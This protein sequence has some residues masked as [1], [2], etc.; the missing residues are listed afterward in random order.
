MISATTIPLLLLVATVLAAFLIVPAMADTKY[1]TGS[2]QIS[3]AI[4]GTNEFSPGD[5][6]TLM[7]VVENRGLNEW[8]FARSDI[9]DPGDL[10]N[11]AKL[12]TVAMRPG[13]APVTVKSDPQKIGDLK[14]G[15]KIVV[16]FNTKIFY[17]AAAGTYNLPLDF[18]YTYLWAADQYGLD[19]IQYYYRVKNDT[20]RLPIKIKAEVRPG[21]ISAVPRHLNV[22]SEGYLDLRVKNIGSLAGKKAVIRT[23]QSG[24]SPVIPT[25]NSVY[26]G[27]FPVNATMDCTFKISASRD[28]QGQTYPLDVYV[29][30]E[31]QNGDTVD[32]DRAT[33]GVPVGKKIGFA[34]ASPPEEIPPGTKKVITVEY[35]NTGDTTVYSAQARISTVNPFTSDD[36]TAYLGDLAPGQKAAARFGISVARD[37]TLKE[38]GLDSEVRYRDALDNSLISDI[39]KVKIDVVPQT[40]LGVIFGN[41]VLMTVIAA[42]IIGI[43]YAVLRYRKR[44]G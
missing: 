3:A 19:S 11:T 10:P 23:A 29:T 4:S 2:P 33:I 13:G 16:K 22:G 6:A 5:N 35:R 39:I 44:H 1:M 43:G 15:D 14:G 18:N 36:D 25:E 38:Y 24:S 41:P 31:D 17:D 34:I 37:A 27:D 28:A 26:I 12:M 9:V 21:V 42:A 20:I 32:S 8:K 30:Y 40:G 7:V